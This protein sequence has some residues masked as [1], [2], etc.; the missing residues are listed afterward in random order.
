MM[1]EEK[2]AS[3]TYD[4]RVLGCKVNAYEAQ[5]IR[6]GLELSGFRPAA[7][8]ESADVVV[9]HTC[10]VTSTAVKKSRQTVRRL[11]KANPGARVVV[12]GCAASENLLA[13]LRDV[14]ARIGPREGWLTE[15]KDE[16][17]DLAGEVQWDAENLAIDTFHAHSRAF[18]KVQDGCDIGCTFCIVP[19]LRR[20]PRDKPLPQ[21]AE[22]AK[23]LAD[24]GHKEIVICGVSVGL[25][26]RDSGGPNL[27]QVLRRV[28]E[29]PGVERI[30]LSSLHPGELTD[31]LLDVWAASPRILPHLHLPLQSGSDRILAAM[32]RNYTSSEFRAAVDRAREALDNPAFNT[33]VIT[34]FPGESEEDFEESVALSKEVG[35]SRMHVFPYSPRPHTRAV[36]LKGHI[37]PGVAR[38][39]TRRLSQVAA[40]L[41]SRFHD[42]FQ[43]SKAQVLVEDWNPASSTYRGYTE[44]YISVQFEGAAGLRGE[45]VEVRLENSRSD[46]VMAELQ[47]G[48][49][50]GHEKK[51]VYG[52]PRSA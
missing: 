21:I 41:Q 10:A 52:L 51:T 28:A 7:E 27:A 46:P 18:L 34:G 32:K 11:Q 15:F 45:I 36:R 37:D 39:R 13:S 6:H 8:G 35:F 12:T 4:V 17:G 49:S 3:G 14:H 26:G 23:R 38:E 47:F 1:A 44:R 16:V 42:Q 40:T 31:E 30:R 2:N 24:S 29:V 33:D 48:A 22:E 20:A 43:G 50:Q 5:Q 9:V 25:Y 19:K